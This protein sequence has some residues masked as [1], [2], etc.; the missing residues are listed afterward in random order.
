M[1]LS[2]Y[3]SIKLNIYLGEPADRDKPQHAGQA[4]RRPGAQGHGARDRQGLP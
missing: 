2:D 3:L 4:A 1:D